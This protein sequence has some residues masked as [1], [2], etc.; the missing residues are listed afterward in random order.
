MVGN[1]YKLYVYVKLKTKMNCI[2]KAY[3]YKSEYE[4]LDSA[5]EWKY[6]FNNLH[7]LDVYQ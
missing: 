5:A 7:T 3:N 2:E 1:I 6:R 4:L